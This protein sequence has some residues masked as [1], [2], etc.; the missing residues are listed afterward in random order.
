MMPRA[1]ILRAKSRALFEL[2]KAMRSSSVAADFEEQ[3]DSQRREIT[4][5]VARTGMLLLMADNSQA[6]LDMLEQAGHWRGQK[7]PFWET[8]VPPEGYY[9][10]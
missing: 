5:Q 4:D 9:P 10:A 7:D 8:H 1:A 3:S 6:T 2:T